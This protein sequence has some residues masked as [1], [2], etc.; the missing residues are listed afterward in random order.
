VEQLAGSVPED[1][2]FVLRKGADYRSDAFASLMEAA[3]SEAAS[4]AA[5]AELEARYS[6]RE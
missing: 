2:K 5:I 3:A 1:F 4:E 6:S